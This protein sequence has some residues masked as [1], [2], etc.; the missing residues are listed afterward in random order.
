MMDYA[1]EGRRFYSV[2]APSK[3]IEF[4]LPERDED[5]TPAEQRKLAKLRAASKEYGAPIQSSAYRLG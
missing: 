3:F 1:A 5:L 2:S 4:E